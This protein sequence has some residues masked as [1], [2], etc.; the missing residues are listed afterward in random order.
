[1]SVLGD[2]NLIVHAEIEEDGRKIMRRF[3]VELLPN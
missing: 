1:M 3:A 2:K